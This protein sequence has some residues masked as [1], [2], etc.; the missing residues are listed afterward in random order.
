MF[1]TWMLIAEAAIG[2]SLTSIKLPGV[3]TTLV[4]FWQTG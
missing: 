3:L 4:F 1:S 2:T